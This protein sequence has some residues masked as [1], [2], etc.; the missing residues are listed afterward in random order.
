MLNSVLLALIFSLVLIPMIRN[1]IAG[2]FVILDVANPF[3]LHLL[4]LFGTSG[5]IILLTGEVS[6]FGLNPDYYSGVYTEGFLAVIIAILFFKAGNNLSLRRVRQL[7]RFM[8]LDWNYEKASRLALVFFVIGFISFILLMQINGGIVFFIQNREYWRAGGLIGQGY[9]LFP[10]TS[11]L[12]FSV[13]IFFIANTH[14]GQKKGNAKTIIALFVISLIPIYFLGFRSLLLVPI[15]QFILL[16]HLLIKPLRTANFIFLFSALLILMLVLGISRSIASNRLLELVDVQKILNT[17]GEE[18]LKALNRSSSM[19]VLPVVIKKVD[20]TGEYQY[21]WRSVFE[22]ATVIV[23]RIIWAEKPISSGERFT[24]YFFGRA[25]DYERGTYKEYWGGV[26]P[27]IL[28]EFYWNFGWFGIVLGSF[29]LGRI[30]KLITS[31]FLKSVHQ[32]NALLAY[33]IIYTSFIMFAEVFQG[34]MNGLILYS[35]VIYFTSKYLKK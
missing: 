10:A 5:A 21:G 22:A 8:L 4:L 35:P 25:L 3:L 2:K 15:I 7:P 18:V 26:S 29:F 23:P 33:L 24:T 1:V 30:M 11:L 6:N 9:L 28:S 12:T 13:F 19:E 31:S 14:C 20:Q 27:S 17:S 16:W 32:P 34:Q